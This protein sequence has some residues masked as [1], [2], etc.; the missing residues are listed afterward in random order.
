MDK[1][2]RK[3]LGL[4]TSSDN[5]RRCAA[6]ITLAELAPK[7]AAVVKALG[8]ALA[9]AGQGLTPYLLDA[10]DATGAKAAVP[11]V[12]PLLSS[13]DVQIK[14]RA[15]QIVSGA[16][17]NVVPHVKK[18]LAGARRGQKLI[19]GDLLAR[20]PTREAYKALLELLFDSDFQV[21]RETCDAV[22]RHVV[23]ATPTQ[24]ANLHKQVVE[25][26]KSARVQK[27]ERVMTS[28][29]LLIGHIAR[30]EA[31]T[32][33]LKHA[34]P[35]MS[36]YI[37][38]HALLGLK[39]LEYT[40]ATARS[41][42]QPL[43]QYLKDKDGDVMRQSLDTLRRLPLTGVGIAQ[44]DRLLK[45]DRGEVRVFAARKIAETDNAA[46]NKRLVTLLEHEDTE[47]S[48]IA[49]AAL[50]HHEKAT[51]L[52]IDVLGKSKSD[53]TAWRLVKILKPH[54]ASL[55]AATIKK[56]VTQAA[57]DVGTGKARGDALLYLLRNAKPQAADQVL[58]DA[59]I[60]HKRAK[61][62]DDAINC[63]RRL[64]QS[65]VCDDKTRYALAV[66]NLKKSPR[67]LSA[68]MRAEDHALRGFQNLSRANFKLLN[69]LKKDKTL[70]AQD[71][72]YVGFHF[73]EARAPQNDFGRDVL[74]HVGKTWPRSKEGQ[75]ARVKTGLSKPKKSAAKKRTKKTTKKLAGK[76]KKKAGKKGSNKNTA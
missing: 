60:K 30:P 45:S 21:I 41:V 73:S 6:A 8:E 67:E 5:M 57:R 71:L 22:R 72:Y 55:P 34:A 28:C 68:H 43:F 20:I 25:F 11:Y 66:C 48:E 36:P 64:T 3:I 4:L 33:L 39:S 59:G 46:N 61:R 9:D 69:E 62:W 37:R 19:L 16:G 12:M 23:G 29:L 70:D 52:L 14:L 24:R 53:E 44:W 7:D 50:A 75:A 51:A 54:A 32:A 2:T 63:L 10:L 1:T 31:R 56:F 76:S 17:A 74:L 26:M 18:E 65:P 47:V 58:L 35:K 27:T 49:A 15:I 13:D 40:P 38:R 42:S